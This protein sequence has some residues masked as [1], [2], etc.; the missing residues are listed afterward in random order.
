LNLLRIAFMGHNRLVAER[1]HNF[2]SQVEATIARLLLRRQN[3]M[4]PVLCSMVKCLRD[5]GFTVIVGL[6]YEQDAAKMTLKSS[7]HGAQLSGRC[8]QRIKEL[9]EMYKE[10]KRRSRSSHF[11]HSMCDSILTVSG[12]VLLMALKGGAVHRR[13]FHWSLPP[14][15]MP[16]GTTASI[17]AA[18]SRMPIRI[19]SA[20]D[21]QALAQHADAVIGMGCM[22]KASPNVS[23]SSH[24]RGVVDELPSN[25]L[26]DDEWCDLHNCNNMKVASKDLCAMTAKYYTMAT[27]MKSNSYAAGAIARLDAYVSDKLVRHCGLRPDTA[28]VA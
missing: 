22:D 4:L 14:L 2:A 7:R 10:Q 13:E 23:Y 19:D 15:A 3:N 20:D 5:N 26:Y 18:L 16:D 28:V 1:Q 8:S 11:Q 17:A 12:K 27:V 6:N 9:D 24:V 21:L 25:I